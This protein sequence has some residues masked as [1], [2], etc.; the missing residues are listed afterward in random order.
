MEERRINAKNLTENTTKH[1][2]IQRS[3]SGQGV[4][5]NRRG[6]GAIWVKLKVTRQKDNSAGE[7]N[8][9]ED[10]QQQTIIQQDKR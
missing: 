10:K 8:R 3:E 1:M 4:N 2:Q 7:Q 5:K 6:K 9:Q